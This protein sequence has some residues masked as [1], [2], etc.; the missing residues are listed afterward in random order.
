MEKLIAAFDKNTS[1]EVR[2]ELSNFK[3]HDLVGVRV[4]AMSNAS[5]DQVPTRKGLTLNVRLLPTLIEGLQAAE[6]EASAAGLLPKKDAT[7]PRSA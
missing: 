6:T 7:S 1:E 4:Y 5:G 3:G 2:V